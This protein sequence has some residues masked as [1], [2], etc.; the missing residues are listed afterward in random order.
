MAEPEMQESLLRAISQLTAAVTNTGLYSSSHPQV[1][2]YIDRAYDALDEML[3]QKPEITLLLIGGDLVAD[4]RPLAASGA[5]SFLA[6]FI[7][8]LKRKSIERLTFVSGMPK[9]ELRALILDLASSDAAPVHAT[10]FIRIGKVELRVRKDGEPDAAL[11]AS[12]AS[13]EA[14]RELLSLTGAELDALCRRLDVAM[15]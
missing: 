8:I 12:D 14:M 9:A 5:A 1:A 11:P 4:N 2:A 10:P 15:D 3:R 7:R 6:N 13:E